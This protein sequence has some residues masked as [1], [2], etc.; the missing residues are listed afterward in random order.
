MQPLLFNFEELFI[1]LGALLSPVQ[2]SYLLS[3][4]MAEE[5]DTSELAELW[6]EE[7]IS[8][9]P[10]FDNFCNIHQVKLEE[11]LDGLSAKLFKNLEDLPQK[12]KYKCS[13]L[14]SK[15][16]DKRNT[17]CEKMYWS[18]SMSSRATEVNNYL[19]KLKTPRSVDLVNLFYLFQQNIHY[20]S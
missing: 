20:L 3:L 1:Q 8:Q 4:K 19:G 6:S 18:S 13:K 10:T 7:H 2:A 17:A 14:K 11:A 15:D 16:K 5:F 12:S 9:L